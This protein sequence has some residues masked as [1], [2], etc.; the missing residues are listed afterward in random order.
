MITELRQLDAMPASLLE[1]MEQQFLAEGGLRGFMFKS[2]LD[3]R[4]SH[5]G[6]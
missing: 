2:R 1:K 4:K 6:V 5:L 3:W